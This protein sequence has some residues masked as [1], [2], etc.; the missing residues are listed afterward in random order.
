MNLEVVSWK[1]DTTI[2]NGTDFT[3]QFVN[4]AAT[5]PAP[6]DIIDAPRSGFPPEYIDFD[7]EGFYFPLRIKCLASSG[8]AALRDEVKRQFN[9]QLREGLQYLIAK[10]IDDSDKLYYRLCKPVSYSPWQGQLITVLLYS[11]EQIWT[12]YDEDT[13]VWSVTASGDYKDIAIGGTHPVA[14]RIEIKPTGA[15]TGNL[16]YRRF[17]TIYNNLSVA[18]PNEPIDVTGGGM[19]LG[20]LLA[21][22]GQ[23]NAINQVGGITAGDSTIPIDTSVGGGLPTT[24]LGFVDSEQIQWTGNSGGNLTGVTR[25]VNGTT[26]ATHADDAVIY[27]SLIQADGD[28]VELRIGGSRVPRWF[29]GSLTGSA[30]KIWTTMNLAAKLE[31]TVSAM[32]AAD[33]SLSFQ[34]NT[35]NK[36]NF[37]LLPDRGIGYIGTELISWDGRVANTLTLQN[38]SRGLEGTTAAIH[39]AGVTLRR[40]EFKVELAYGDAAA[41]SYIQ[42]DD[43]KPIFNLAN[44]TNAIWKYTGAN[45]STFSGVRPGEWKGSVIKD[46][47]PATV[48]QSELYTGSHHTV[49]DPAT[50]MGLA[51]GSWLNGSA[52]KADTADL[53][54]RISHPVGF[55]DIVMNG[56]KY[57]SS[58][59]WVSGSKSYAGLQ[60]SLDGKK[61]V[62]IWSQSTPSSTS[63]YQGF[64]GSPTSL[65]GTYPIARLRLA[66]AIAAAVDVE[67][68]LEVDEAE[69]TRG[70]S[71]PSVVLG[72]ESSNYEL[73]C[74]LSVDQTGESIKVAYQMQTNETLVVDCFNHRVFKKDDNTDAYSA[75]SKSTVRRDWLNLMPGVT[76]RITITDPGIGNVQVTVYTR[77]RSH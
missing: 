7:Q 76:N 12:A 2:V 75:I 49:E 4:G 64:T 30:V 17:I 11:P 24:G 77:T 65:S 39:A 43:Y 20:A 13:T 3:S 21:Y 5:L 73:T 36:N 48:R 53:E 46:V 68:A 69:L 67:N 62:N 26:A 42:S 9:P 70:S 45:F 60:V 72:S 38:L 33:T 10:D 1:G 35:T 27:L 44:S 71:I 22:T 32:T 59:G 14:P 40:I 63:S 15:R 51:I 47:A 34:N 66:G 54:W 41:G 18:L 52:W 6:I 58:S 28:D 37:K 74:E 56:D 61:W 25:G 55:T 50:F 31:L 19:D 16:A 23:S 29:S 57:R 8:L